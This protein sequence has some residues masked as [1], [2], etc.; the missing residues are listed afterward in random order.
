MREQLIQ[1]VELLFAGAADCDSF[2]HLT[3]L[4][5]CCK[6]MGECGVVATVCAV[7]SEVLIVVTFCCEPLLNLFLEGEA[8]MVASQSYSLFFHYNISFT[9]L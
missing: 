9:C 4:D 8:C 3:L 6:C 7:G 1:Y 2:L 5:C